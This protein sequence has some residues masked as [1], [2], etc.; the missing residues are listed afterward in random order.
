MAVWNSWVFLRE[1]RGVADALHAVP[2]CSGDCA[3]HPARFI[4]FAQL[5]KL[6]VFFIFR[7]KFPILL[8]IG[9]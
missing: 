8:M 7:D 1:T 6:C 4:V 2:Y 3:H 5:A 9:T